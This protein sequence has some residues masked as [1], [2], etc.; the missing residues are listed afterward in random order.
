MAALLDLA[1]QIGVEARADVAHEG[2]AAFGQDE[3]V[4]NSAVRFSFSRYNTPAEVDRALAGGHVLAVRGS[5]LLVGVDLD[6]PA[7]GVI[8]AARARGLLVINAG[9]ITL[10]IAPPLIV[11]REHID[12]AADILG[13]CLSV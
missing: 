6:I 1:R 10:R 8:A 2:P 12:A 7:A 4:A 11:T 5:G 3:A 9:E 13:D